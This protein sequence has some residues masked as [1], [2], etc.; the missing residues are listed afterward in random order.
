MKKNPK[1]LVVSLLVLAMV[2]VSVPCIIAAAE[3]ANKVSVFGLLPYTHKGVFYLED[4]AY[5]QGAAGW[6]AWDKDFLYYFM[7]DGATKGTY[8]QI[9]EDPKLPGTTYIVVGEWDESYSD[10]W[11]RAKYSCSFD[12]GG[13]VNTSFA[14]DISAKAL[15]YLPDLIQSLKTSTNMDESPNIDGLTFSEY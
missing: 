8:L 4:Y 7:D 5:D 11:N 12:T 6:H 10:H 13:T 14:G 3:P 15:F 2:F 1:L 9:G